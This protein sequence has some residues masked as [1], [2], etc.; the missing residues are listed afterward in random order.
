MRP[1][2]LVVIVILFSTSCARSP[3]RMVPRS[4]RDGPIPVSH[5]VEEFENYRVYAAS[6]VGPTALVFDPKSDDMS[7]ETGGRFWEELESAEELWHYIEAMQDGYRITNTTRTILLDVPG[8]E[9]TAGYI[10]TPGIA[11]IRPSES[12]PNTVIV[13]WVRKEQACHTQRPLY[14]TPISESLCYYIWQDRPRGFGTGFGA[15]FGLG[16]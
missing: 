6:H 11:R 2:L 8:G 5:F 16:W 12:D 15:G 7:I 1:W 3:V 4:D 14:F 13:D 9:V 10:Y